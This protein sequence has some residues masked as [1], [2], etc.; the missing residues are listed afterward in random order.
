MKAAPTAPR[1]S[2]PA[3]LRP[4]PETPVGCDGP[5]EAAVGWVAVDQTMVVEVPAPAMPV[6][7]ACVGST[8][9]GGIIVWPS[10]DEAVA[11]VEFLPGL[12]MV[13][14]P[15]GPVGPTG[16]GPVLDAEVVVL[17]AELPHSSF[18]RTENC[19][20]YWKMPVLSSM[21]SMP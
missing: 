19:V 7:G 5:V 20:L 6:A 10:S 17:L 14:L 2:A 8:V 1:N 21:M 13:P 15:A 11:Q 16:P 4:A 12:M 18:S 3:A 9:V